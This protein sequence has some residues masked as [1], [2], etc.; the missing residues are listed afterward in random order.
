MLEL[1]CENDYQ[2]LFLAKNRH[3]SLLQGPKP[4]LG[5]ERGVNLHHHHLILSFLKNTMKYY[6]TYGFLL[7]VSACL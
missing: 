1:F 6:E 4:I 2:L 3:W 7:L 5:G